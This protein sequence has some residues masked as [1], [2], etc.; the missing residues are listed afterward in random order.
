MVQVPNTVAALTLEQQLIVTVVDKLL[1][2]TTVLIV[3]Y[4]V[5]RAIERYRSDQAR[6]KE[7]DVLRDKEALR[8]LQRQIEEL[9]SPLFGPIKYSLNVFFIFD[10]KKQNL[11]A[12]QRGELEQYFTEKHFLKI[13]ASMAEL[14]RSKIYLI[15][16]PSIPQSFYDFLEHE[17]TFAAQYMLWEER[18]ISSDEIRGKGW[19]IAIEADVYSVLD[20]LRAEYNRLLLRVGSS[21]TP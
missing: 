19:P 17:S 18:G 6:R 11:P 2:G 7:F 14:I 20:R 4:F 16:T 5:T 1:I 21:P 12:D 10:K 15:A 13:N 9:Y 8:H 3:G